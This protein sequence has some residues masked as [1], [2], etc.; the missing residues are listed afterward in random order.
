[1]V[2]LDAVADLRRDI[3]LERQILAPALLLARRMGR[4]ENLRFCPWMFAM[5]SDRLASQDIGP[6]PP[7]RD[8]R[9]GSRQKKESDT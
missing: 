9:R 4:V 7:L 3:D 2:L 5:R 6:W 1:L 8:G